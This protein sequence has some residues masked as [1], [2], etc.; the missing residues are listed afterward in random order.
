VLSVTRPGCKEKSEGT[1]Q[2]KDAVSCSIESKQRKANGFYLPGFDG[3]V[4]QLVVQFD[5]FVLVDCRAGGKG[6]SL[7]KTVKIKG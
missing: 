3:R 5:D 2:T 6:Q 1:A 4:V 7:L